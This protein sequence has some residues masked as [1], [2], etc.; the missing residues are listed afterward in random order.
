MKLFAFADEAS[1]AI[2][3]QIAAMQRN[4]LQG[5]EIRI[6]DGTNVSEISLEKAK[7]VRNKLDDAGMI[8]WSIGSPIG[9]IHIEKDD[10]DAHLDKFKHTLE[11]AQ[12]LGAENIRLFSFFY[13]GKDP[14]S[15]KNKV[16]DR[17]HRFVELNKGTNIDLCH[18]NES[19]I[20]GD[21]AERCLQIHQEVPE[22][23]GIFDPANFVQCHQQVLPAWELLKPYI[24]Y[25]HIKDARIDGKNCPAGEGAGCIP[26][27]L[28]KFTAQGGSAVTLEPHLMLTDDPER[29]GYPNQS[30]AFDVAC[31]ALKKIL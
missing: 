3:A 21:V 22:L 25:L 11:V 20:Y 30:V 31:N 28:A 15:C 10:F 7:E 2:D 16:M 5:L 4:G 23:K 8:T 1:F 9:K 24:K 12:I 17:L 27:I 18:E 19:A 14:A 29:W 13:E 6:V 26:E